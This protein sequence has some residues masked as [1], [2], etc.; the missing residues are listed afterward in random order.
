MYSHRLSTRH[1][2]VGLAAGGATLPGY[3]PQQTTI[4]PRSPGGGGSTAD[5]TG[6]RQ[7]RYGDGAAAGASTQGGNWMQQQQQQQQMVC[8]CASLS[9][10]VGCLRSCVMRDVIRQASAIPAASIGLC[11]NRSTWSRAFLR[12][13]AS[14]RCS[15]YDEN[16]LIIRF[17]PP[18]WSNSRG[19]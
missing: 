2:C 13:K 12:S 7:V 9:G 1:Y 18:R 5:L 17:G 15:H 8:F 3:L 14:S 19:G 11:T 16:G 10:L 6:G 4:R